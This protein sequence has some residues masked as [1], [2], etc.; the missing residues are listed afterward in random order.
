LRLVLDEHLSPS[1][2]EQLRACGHDMVTVAEAG[3]AGAA[4]ERVLSG[5]SARGGRW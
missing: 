4:D 5:R 2:A 1:I 3:L